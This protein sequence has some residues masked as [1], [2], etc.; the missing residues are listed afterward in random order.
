MKEIYFAKR[1][2][3]FLEKLYK[4]DKNLAGQIADGLKLLRDDPLCSSVKKL[5][6]AKDFYRLRIGKYRIIY[7]FDERSVYIIL[8][9]KREEVYEKLRNLAN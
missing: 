5:A 2:E 6:G 8:I 4:S 7:R 1:V 3:K 9:A